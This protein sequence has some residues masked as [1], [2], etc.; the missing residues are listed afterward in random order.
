AAGAA[1]EAFVSGL[2]TS[3]GVSAAVAA[4]GAVL[5]LLLIGARRSGP[6]ADAVAPGPAGADPQPRGAVAAI[7]RRQSE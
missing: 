7:A 2:T 3:I 4:A 6:A 1:R 5:A